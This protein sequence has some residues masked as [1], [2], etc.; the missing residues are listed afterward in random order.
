MSNLPSRYLI[1]LIWQNE[2]PD[3]LIL[4]CPPKKKESSYNVPFY[5]AQ[6]D[7]VLPML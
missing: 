2:N 7:E 1:P 6:K 4:T 3:E 5:T